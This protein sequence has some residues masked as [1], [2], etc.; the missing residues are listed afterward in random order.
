[1]LP[2]QV[3]GR[4]HQCVRCDRQARED[5]RTGFGERPPGLAGVVHVDP[6]GYQPEA[7]AGVGHALPPRIERAGP[8]PSVPDDVV[9]VDTHN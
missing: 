8:E 5:D 2:V 4:S 9:D 3:C 6:G 7:P 1:V